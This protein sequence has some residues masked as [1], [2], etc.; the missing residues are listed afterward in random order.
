M[1]RYMIYCCPGTGGLFLSTVVAQ[2]L[3]YNVQSYFSSTGH[4]HN[5]GRGNWRGA[6]NICLIGDHWDINYRYGQP[7]YYSHVIRTEFLEQNPDVNIIKINAD[8]NDYKKVAEIYV[9][10][11]WPDLWTKE[12]YAKWASV[13]YPPYSKDNIHTSELIRND[14]INDL[15]ITTVKK[16][17]DDNVGMCAHAEI[18]FRT[19]MG[20]DGK[21]LVIAVCS[22]LNTVATEQIQNYVQK[23]QQLNQELYFAR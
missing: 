6:N 19:I 7:I 21:D 10:K 4:A 3:G 8:P 13:E 16:W 22:I 15:E 2:L 14:L 11:A 1:N 5:M 12:E 18:N 9:K 23:Y 20:I 17:Y